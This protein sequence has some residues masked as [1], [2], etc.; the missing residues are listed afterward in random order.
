MGCFAVKS[1]SF[2]ILASNRN[3]AFDPR[4]LLRRRRRRTSHPVAVLTA[5][6]KIHYARGQSGL[7]ERN[8]SSTRHI[9]ASVSSGPLARSDETDQASRDFAP[10]RDGQL[11]FM[12]S[13]YCSVRHF[14]VRHI[15][16]ERNQQPAGQRDDGDAPDP[17]TF[18]A[19][20]FAEPAAQCAI[21][22]MSYPQP[23]K[24]DQG[25]AQTRVAGLRYSLFAADLAAL[26][27]SGYET[28]IGR[29]LPAI[30]EA[31]EQALKIEHAGEFGADTL[32]T[33]E[34]GHRRAR[35]RRSLHLRKRIAFSFDF[36]NLAQQ[37]FESLDLAQDLGL[38][39]GRQRS[40][41]PVLSISSRSRRPCAT[42]YNP[43]S[44]G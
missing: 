17:A 39:S 34:R 42:D 3:P 10:P 32:E 5:D 35:D 36:S 9:A 25:L 6:T 38:Q 18:D 7:A 8:H 44:P 15:A 27:R 2:C 40:P 29:H 23:S 30:A 28:C 24:F 11:A 22:L 12:L 20:S 19:N 33:S 21:W 41:S 13:S 4:C 16:P 37:H 43:K 14:T 26:P 31:A 1:V